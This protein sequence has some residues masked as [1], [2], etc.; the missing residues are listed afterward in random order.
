VQWHCRQLAPGA[1]SGH[2]LLH[3]NAGS[4]REAAGRAVGAAR[5]AAPGVDEAQRVEA[6]RQLLETTGR[7]L[8]EVAAGAGF[9]RVETMH[10]VFQRALRVSPGQYRRHFRAA[11]RRA[12]AS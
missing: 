12:T 8:E 4:G 11:P 2:A 5:R 6:A 10:R 9:G 7:G 1:S 3:A